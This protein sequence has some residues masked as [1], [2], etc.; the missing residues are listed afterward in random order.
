MKGLSWQA[1]PFSLPLSLTPPLSPLVSL[2][3]ASPDTELREPRQWEQPRNLCQ[4][5]QLWHH[6]PGK[7]EDPGCSVQEHAILTATT[8]CRHGSRW[9]LRVESYCV[10]QIVYFCLYYKAWVQTFK[11]SHGTWSVSIMTGRK[12]KHELG[13]VR[14][15][16][17][18][19]TMQTYDINKGSTSVSGREPPPRT[20]LQP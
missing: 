15:V 3:P 16:I 11:I 1:K 9:D 2:Y 20:C 17:T 6:Y 4:G 18:D 14:G 5:A 13:H 8:S 10:T 12:T 19:V 7:G